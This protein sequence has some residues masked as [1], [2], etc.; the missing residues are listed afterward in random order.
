MDQLRLGTYTGS[1]AGKSQQMRIEFD[2]VPPVDPAEE[3][4]PEVAEDFEIVRLVSLG[5]KN[6]VRGIGV[7]SEGTQTLVEK[8]EAVWS[9]SRTEDSWGRGMRSSAG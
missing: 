5:A 6:A 1:A 8:F 3:V 9:R 2:R 4:R 7:L